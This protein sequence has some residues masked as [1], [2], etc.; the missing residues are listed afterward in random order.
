MDETLS[1]LQQW[2]ARQCDGEWEHQ[3]GVKIE[4]L[5]NP[6]WRVT[7]DLTGTDLDGRPFEPQG[8]RG[9]NDESTD[10]RSLFV[11]DGKFEGAGDPTKLTFILRTFLDWA[12]QTDR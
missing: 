6:G 2:Y 7:I 4:T 12:E 11:E 1:R 9:W 8:G 5:D 10:W 3:Y